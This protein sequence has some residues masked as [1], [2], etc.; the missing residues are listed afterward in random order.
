MPSKNE[1]KIKKNNEIASIKKKY[2]SLNQLKEIISIIL[3]KPKIDL[4]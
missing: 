2:F 4:S 1:D 3:L